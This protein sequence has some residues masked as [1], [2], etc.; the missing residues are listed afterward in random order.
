MR[1]APSESR[2]P[3]NGAQPIWRGVRAWF[4]GPQAGP[5]RVA[6]LAGAVVL[7]VVILMTWVPNGDSSDAT[8][9]IDQGRRFAP[10]EVARVVDAL[11]LKGLDP[12][13][14]EPGRISVP[15]SQRVAAV[16]VM[17]S[18][19]LRV[20]SP[21]DLRDD[22][23]RPGLLDGPA[24]GRR[25]EMLNRARIVESAVE[26][27][28]GLLSATVTLRE[29]DARGYGRPRRLTAGVFLGVEADE[30]VPAETIRRILTILRTFEPTLEPERDITIID[31][32]GLAYY[33][34]G[35][36]RLAARAMADARAQEWESDL[37]S[38]LEWIEGLRVSVQI[39]SREELPSETAGPVV[40]PASTTPPRATATGSGLEV[41]VNAPARVEAVEPAEAPAPKLSSRANVLVEIPARYY[42]ERH[43][44]A[45]EGRRPSPSELRPL[46]EQTEQMV[47]TAVQHVI[48]PDQMGSVHIVEIPAVEP[49]TPV[50]PA[51]AAGPLGLSGTELRTLIWA[52]GATGM[53]LVVLIFWLTARRQRTVAREPF[54]TL[55]TPEHLDRMEADN[56]PILTD[57]I[58]DL[59]RRDPKA[60][61]GVVQRWIGQGGHVG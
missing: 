11:T 35:D 48:P 46:I 37:L 50:A 26:K 18:M 32:R 53:G 10:E 23:L 43:L 7:G 55:A 8:Y 25:L 44:A 51:A 5:R 60:A 14:H 1:T 29:E 27:L 58:R 34:A 6:A 59:V 30:R 39:E 21:K 9:W 47:R 2:E 19:G 31:Q 16:K 49:F 15:L 28:P 17:Q 54:R 42:W 36:T 13:V 4:D 24:V 57:R 33:V 52:G 20:R 3:E 12:V 41:I 38:R 61:A 22:P 40:A 56:G 45:R